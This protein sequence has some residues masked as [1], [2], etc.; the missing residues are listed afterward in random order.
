M[1]RLPRK[2]QGSDSRTTEWNAAVDYM[3]SLTPMNSKDMLTDHTV[4][5]V[6]RKPKGVSDLPGTIKV[7][8][9][10][11]NTGKVVVYLLFGRLVSSA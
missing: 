4:H 10:D 9:C 3:A 11:P 2:F 6:F 8:A 5:G 1:P 7:T